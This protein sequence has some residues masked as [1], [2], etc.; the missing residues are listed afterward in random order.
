ARALA[1]EVVVFDGSGA[2]IPP[3]AAD[4][5][6]LVVGRGDDEG[7]YLNPYRVLLADAVVRIGVDAE[8]ELQ[9]LE[10]LEGRV[11]VFTAGAT[12]V[13]HLEADVVHVSAS[14]AHRELLRRELDA[15]AEHALAHGRRVVL[16]RN[17]LVG[18]GVDELLLGAAPAVVP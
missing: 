5:R 3:I 17:D 4:R 7:A 8:L 10:P 13:S 1:P 2:S 6:I 12:D 9:P 16:G 11:A 15:V 14:L 18:D